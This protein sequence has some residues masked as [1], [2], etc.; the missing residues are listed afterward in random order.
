MAATKDFLRSYL[1]HSVTD[2]TIFV[3]HSVTSFKPS[4]QEAKCAIFLK[5]EE[6][7]KHLFPMLS[8]DSELEVT[9]SVAQ[10]SRP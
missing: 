8:S 7:K 4:R 9:T 3:Q 6:K 1:H 2:T 10:I 5:K